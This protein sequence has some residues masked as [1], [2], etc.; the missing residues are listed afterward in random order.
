MVVS[1][2]G[3]S[4]GERLMQA[5]RIRRRCPSSLEVR[6]CGSIDKAKEGRVPFLI[7]ADDA[8]RPPLGHC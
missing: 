4:T 5:A 3:D 7:L 8:L 1:S 6:S 2:G